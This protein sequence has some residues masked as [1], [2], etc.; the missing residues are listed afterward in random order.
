MDICGSV[1]LVIINVSCRTVDHV[2]FAVAQGP[3]LCKCGRLLQSNAVTGRCKCPVLH[4]AIPYEA[5]AQCCSSQCTPSSTHRKLL[6]HSAVPRNGALCPCL[7][8][9]FAIPH[10]HTPPGFCLELLCWWRPKTSVLHCW[11]PQ[12]SRQPAAADHRAVRRPVL[13]LHIRRRGIGG[14]GRNVIG[15]VCWLHGSKP[16][17]SANLCK[18]SCNMQRRR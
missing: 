3:G 16:H 4:Y 5:I 11:L 8:N 13:G 15:R 12:R 6:W 9:H 17:S 10:T 7:V 2:H 1:V 14:E 18:T